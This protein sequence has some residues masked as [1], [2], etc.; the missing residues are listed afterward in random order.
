MLTHDD[1]LCPY[2]DIPMVSYRESKSSYAFGNPKVFCQECHHK[3]YDPYCN[4]ENCKKLREDQAEILR[5][6]EAKLNDAKRQI[7]IESY[8]YENSMPIS[9]DELTIK[10]KLYICSLLRTCLSE[11]FK[12]I[13]PLS[14]VKSNLA[15]TQQYK[16]NIISYLRSKLI[17]LFSPSTSLHSIVIENNEIQSYYPLDV[18]L[19]LNASK[20]QYDEVV[21][22]L[23]HLNIDEEINNETK[24]ELWYEIGLFECL[25]FLYAKMDEY[26]LPSEHVGDKTISAIKES[27]KDFSISQ[28]FNFIWRAVTNAAAFYQK[29]SVSKNMLLIPFQDPLS[30]VMKKPKQ[31]IGM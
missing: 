25:E 19:K 1:I 31:K 28:N 5:Q 11:D 8:E 22:D 26:N 27:L 15:P 13:N 4:C 20:E 3:N 9:I 18:T 2:C 21:Q 24:L 16:M 30:E 17:V 10:D 6:K 23:L 12:S 14:S 7:L 29:S